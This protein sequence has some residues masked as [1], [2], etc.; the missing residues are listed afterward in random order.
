[1]SLILDALKKLEQ[2]KA[3]RRA[4]QVELRPAITGRRDSPSS[5]SW[6]LPLL[7]AGSVIVAVAVTISFMGRVS[8]Q[9]LPGA[10]P[11]APVQVESPRSTPP[12]AAVP[13]SAPMP[14][15]PLQSP[16]IMPAPPAPTQVPAP[17]EVRPPPPHRTK[18]VVP[19][20][21][22]PAPADIK[23]TGIAWQDER[24]ARRAIVNGVLIGEGGIIVGAKVVE[25]RPDQ[26]RLSRD[27]QTFA[28][29][30]TSSNR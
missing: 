8:R 5:S 11:P 1:M 25:I 6:R 12:V 16:V 21:T 9:S 27:G 4:R 26:I 14:A 20:M 18:P 22:G 3:A 13:P 2:E 10:P 23:V 19:E 29:S 24:A 17:A 7:I 15:A 30:I 28:V